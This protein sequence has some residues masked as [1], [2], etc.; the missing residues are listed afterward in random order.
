MQFVYFKILYGVK[1]FGVDA[2]K[3]V[4]Q[5]L[6]KLELVYLKKTKAMLHAE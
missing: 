2:H 3:M 6:R 4:L 1:G 5:T